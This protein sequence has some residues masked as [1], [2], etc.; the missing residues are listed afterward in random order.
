MSIFDDIEDVGSGH[1]EESP[2]FSNDAD[3]R[4][5]GRYFK[6][7][8]DL[9]KLYVYN[10]LSDSVK[11]NKSNDIYDKDLSSITVYFAEFIPEKNILECRVKVKYIDYYD[12]Y[13]TEEDR[14]GVAFLYLNIESGQVGY[15]M[16]ILFD[17]YMSYTNDNYGVV[18]TIAEFDSF[19]I[20]IVNE[21]SKTVYD[22][23]DLD[24]GYKFR[25]LK[26]LI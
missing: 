2:L 21:L 18:K 13:A 7:N 25:Y 22:V 12:Y 5:V 11:L 3:I 23:Y 20:K 15:Y 19:I 24:E 6:D 17:S 1:G 4:V 26:R 9:Y 8:I 16:D 10:V 14:H